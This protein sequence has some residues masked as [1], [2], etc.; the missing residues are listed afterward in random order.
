MPL[1]GQ[2][3]PRDFAFEKEGIMSKKP[4][5]PTI[6]CHYCHGDM[7]KDS[8]RINQFQCDKHILPVYAHFYLSADPGFKVINVFLIVPYQNDTYE[9]LMKPDK[10][11]L[12]V[13]PL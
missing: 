12:S 5:T 2:R 4:K 11:F 10:R 6:S 13:Y 7:I 9:M 8:G 1:I 3:T